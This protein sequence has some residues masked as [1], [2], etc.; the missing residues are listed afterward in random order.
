MTLRAPLLAVALVLTACPKDEAPSEDDRLLKKLQAEK[1]RLA[2]GTEAPHPS[3]PAVAPEPNPL[4][5]RAAMP[6]QPKVLPITGAPDFMVGRAACRV[7]AL[8]ASHHVAG[9]K[10]SLTTDDYFFKVTLTAQ[11]LDGGSLDLSQAKLVAGTVEYPI[12]KDAQRLAGSRELNRTLKPDEKIE[13]V[14]Y[15]EAPMSAAVP[16]LKLIVAGGDG[17]SLQ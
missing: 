2:N 8:E 6:D 1:D 14:L 5:A 3:M 15:F 11:V 13:A 12:A 17:V 10:M 16:G 7:S 4:A 9:E